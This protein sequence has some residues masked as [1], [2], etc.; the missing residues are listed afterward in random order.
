MRKAITVTFTD[1]G[2]GEGTS[3]TL[4]CLSNRFSHFIGLGALIP[5]EQIMDRKI[6]HNILMSSM[7]IKPMTT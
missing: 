6:T 7:G 1:F 3:A 2:I 4:W 5:A